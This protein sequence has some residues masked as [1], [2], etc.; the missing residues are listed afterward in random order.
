LR[1]R[2][3]SFWP[4]RL[5]WLLMLATRDLPQVFSVGGSTDKATSR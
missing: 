3:R 2:R 1:T 4:M 5:I